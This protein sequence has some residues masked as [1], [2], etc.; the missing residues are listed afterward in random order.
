MRYLVGAA[1]LAGLLAACSSKP[2]PKPVVVAEVPKDCPT[3]W[4]FSDTKIRKPKKDVPD[5]WKAFSGV[6]GNAGWDGHHCHDLYVME[7]AKDGTVKLMDTHGPGP[8]YSG[9]AFPRVGKIGKDNRLSF[10]ADGIRREYWIFDGKMI[11]IRHLTSTK[12]SH[13]EME[14][15]T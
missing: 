2:E 12:K 11:G 8:K 10:L 4:V 5:E 14:R 15:K 13:I 1:V 3:V 9:T 6:W 7:I